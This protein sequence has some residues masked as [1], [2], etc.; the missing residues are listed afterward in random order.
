MGA[1]ISIIF[2][3]KH[4]I[5]S[6]R[7]KGTELGPGQYPLM[8]YLARNQNI[9]QETLA[10]HFRIDRGAIAR[11]VRK[12][13]EAGYITRITDPDSR[14]AVRLFL[15]RKGEV[16]IPDLVMIEKEWESVIT[17]SLHEQEKTHFMAS[18]KE[19]AKA[20]LNA[21][22]GSENVDLVPAELSGGDCS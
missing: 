2:R 19:A 12:L 18:L 11:S 1:L 10:R 20:A 15:T 13:E 16:I 9:T 7:L 3:T 14:R 22:S 5:I 4:I 21:V 17:R 8:M 6:N